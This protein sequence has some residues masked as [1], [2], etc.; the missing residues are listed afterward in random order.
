MQSIINQINQACQARSEKEVLR[1]SILCQSEV[2]GE[3]ATETETL[4][5]DQLL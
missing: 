5:E 3:L 1:G 2:K 4:L